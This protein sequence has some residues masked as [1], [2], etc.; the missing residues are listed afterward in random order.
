MIGEFA[1]V[2]YIFSVLAIA[3]WLGR[4]GSRM[5]MLE[6]AIRSVSWPLMV[7][8]MPVVAFGYLG[9]ISAGRGEEA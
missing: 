6:L 2:S 7:A 9:R 5:S 1:I 8:V 4:A 3:F